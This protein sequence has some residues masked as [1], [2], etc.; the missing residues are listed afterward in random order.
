MLAPCRMPAPRGTV[1]R[2][3]EKTDRSLLASRFQPACSAATSWTGDN[4]STCGEVPCAHHPD[5]V[6]GRRASGIRIPPGPQRCPGGFSGVPR[7][8]E[9]FSLSPDSAVHAI[10]PGTTG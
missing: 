7:D 4:E 3:A 5:V 9:L 10:L 1:A 2:T 6:L 8:G